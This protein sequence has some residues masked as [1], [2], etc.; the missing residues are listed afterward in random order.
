MG[1]LSLS[2]S[3]SYSIVESLRMKKSG[4]PSIPSLSLSLPVRLS[5]T[6]PGREKFSE[7]R[8]DSLWDGRSSSSTL[9]RPAALCRSLR[10]GGREGGRLSSGVLGV[11]RKMPPREPC[12]LFSRTLALQ[13]GLGVAVVGGGGWLDPD[14]SSSQQQ[15]LKPSYFASTE[16]GRVNKVGKGTRLSDE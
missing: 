16:L 6:S 7:R 9:G 1:D 5:C 2:S 11:C 14:C 12:C 4:T 10:W 8:W 3:V 15:M 13:P